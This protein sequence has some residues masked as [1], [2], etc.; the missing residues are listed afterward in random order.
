MTAA[1]TA[2]TA[3]PATPPAGSTSAAGGVEPVETT[4][5]GPVNADPGDTDLGIAEVLALLA[6]LPGWR[7]VPGT[8][9][10]PGGQPGQRLRGARAVLE[11]LATQPG[12]DW[13]QRWQAGGA[14]HGLDP[15]LG[16][17]S[18][19]RREVLLGLNWLILA[20]VI[21]PGYELFTQVTSY[22]LFDNVPRR[23][24]PELFTRLGCGPSAAPGVLDPELGMALSTSQRQ[25]VRAILV[26]LVLHTGKDLTGLEPD[27]LLD[28]RDA[29][30]GQKWAKATAGLRNAWTLLSRAGVL[31]SESA[32]PVALRRSR[33][34]VAEL[35]DA[36]GIV[37]PTAR[38]VLVR[39]F[40]ERATSL[41]Y[42]SIYQGV[43]T[44]AGTFWADIERHHP[45]I[46]SLALPV[47]VAEA[48]KQRLQHSPKRG[49]PRQAYRPVLTKVRAFYLDIAEWA[50][51]DPSWAEHAVPC[52]IRRAETSGGAKDKK[53]VT[54]RMHQRIRDRMPQLPRLLDSVDQH[55]RTQAELL[56]AATAAEPG[57]VFTVAGVSYRR[58]VGAKEFRGDRYLPRAVR[59]V[60][61]TTGQSLN[62]TR[63]EDLAFWSWAVI[64]TL[65]HTGVRIEELLELTHLALTSHRLPGTGEIVPLLQIVPSK[66]DEERL[67]LVS[68]ELASVLATTIARLRR[69]NGGTIRRVGRWDRYERVVG[70]A[71]PHLFQRSATGHPHGVLSYTSLR[72][73]L[74]AAVTRA[75]LTDTAGEPLEFTPHDFRRIFVTEAISSGLPIHIAARLLGHHSI[76][77]TSAYHAVFDEDLIRAYRGFLDARRALRPPTEYREPTEA[78]WLEFEQHF[79]QRKL[80]LGSCG[81]AYGSP[82]QHEH[83][84]IRCP[85][86]RVDPRQRGRLAEIAHNLTER[87][88]EARANGWHGEVE[89]LQISLTAANTKLAGLAKITA[90]H[91]DLGLPIPPPAVAGSDTKDRTS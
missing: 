17:T 78:E 71:L 72:E 74:N 38:S 79:A 42:N 47:E 75:G 45:G 56:D 14:D 67:L 50:Q 51:T 5:A 73:M 88:A 34:S 68:P 84:C 24:S 62:L 32:L 36:H 43:N 57:A 65:R 18:V 37:S 19:S 41:D 16:S 61:L 4:T 70:P 66:T 7:A 25:D 52:P 30:R 31:P 44:I 1:T 13:Q 12:A 77:T 83:A 60:N 6:R 81:R 54:A 23:I 33:R 29:A 85:V 90:G 46:D 9:H 89:G 10:S 35:V 82:C 39:Y 11:W 58:H 26:K 63:D 15:L 53:R 91:T 69:E 40:E 48:W 49:A 28:L 22:F 2:G 59:A 76:N 20:R 27:D 8:G 64:E 86:L 87:I 21:R 55:R 3:A 80:S